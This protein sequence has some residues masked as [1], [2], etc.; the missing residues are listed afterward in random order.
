MLVERFH[1]VQDSERHLV[2]RHGEDVAPAADARGIPFAITVRVGDFVAPPGFFRNSN[3][4]TVVRVG[5]GRQPL[6]LHSA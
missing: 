3:Q 2:P 1:L 4:Q 5:V 6:G